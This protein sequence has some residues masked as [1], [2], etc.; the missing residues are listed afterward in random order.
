MY[1]KTKNI[2]REAFNGN[3]DGFSRH[4]ELKIRLTMLTL[5]SMNK[6]NKLNTTLDNKKNKNNTTLNRQI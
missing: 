6:T 5:L 2:N 3:R 4:I 1:K